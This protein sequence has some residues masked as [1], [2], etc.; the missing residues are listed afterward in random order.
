MDSFTPRELREIAYDWDLWA[1][2]SQVAPTGDWLT[3]LVMA[4]RGF[5]KNRLAAEWLRQRVNSEDAKRIAIVG[6]TPADVRDVMIEGESGIL[7]VFPPDER[8]MYEPSKRRVTFHTGA[9]GTVYSSE[10]P[11]AATRPSARYSDC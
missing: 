4:G 2:P 3:W 8:P 5:G 11:E 6:R 10:N 7:A 1:R 9:V